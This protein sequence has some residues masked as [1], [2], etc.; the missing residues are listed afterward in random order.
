M[1]FGQRGTHSGHSDR[2]APLLFA[3]AWRLSLLDMTKGAVFFKELQPTL[4]TESLDGLPPS[5]RGEAIFP[6]KQNG[7]DVMAKDT[8]RY[9]TS[10]WGL[11]LDL[12][13]GISLV[14]AIGR[15]CQRST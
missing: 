7:A 4:L 8:K 10:G 14:E 11:G 12:Y 5:P 1:L 9:A 2:D 13:R 6:G 3:R 15:S